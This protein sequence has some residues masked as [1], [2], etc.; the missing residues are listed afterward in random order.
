[1]Q[2]VPRSEL[3]TTGLA[4]AG[5]DAAGT[6]H[7]GTVIVCRRGQF[8]E[9]A[10]VMSCDAGA[11]PPLLFVFDDPPIEFDEYAAL[12]EEFEL[13]RRDSNAG[14]HGAG[15]FREQVGSLR[16]SEAEQVALF[17]GQRTARGR[18]AP[19][20]SWAKRMAMLRDAVREA[21]PRRIVYLFSPGD[22]LFKPWSADA[23]PAEGDDAVL[24]GIVDQWALLPEG[25]T[26][27]AGRAANVHCYR[28]LH[29]LH[30]LG[31]SLWRPKVAPGDFVAVPT[32]GGAAHYA[33]AL[34]EALRRN[35]PVRPL[36]GL[37]QSLEQVCR[38]ANAEGCNDGL[39]VLVEDQPD[40]TYLLAA[41]H[42]HEHRARIVAVPAPDQP[43]IDAAIAAVH[44]ATQAGPL[45]PRMFV[46][47]RDS[48]IPAE[49]RRCISRLE[50][51]V[52]AHLERWVVEE[53]GDASLTAF[54]GG[55]PY[56]FARLGDIGWR[57]KAIGHVAGDP[58]LL[59][60]GDLYSGQAARRPCA[61]NLVLDPG[62]FSR[63]E[64]P[65]VTRELAEQGSV[66]VPLSGDAACLSAI[67]NIAPQAA[68]ETLFFIT[69][70][71]DTAIKL[72][73]YVL[74]R[75]DIPQW[76]TL[77]SRPIVFNNSCQSWIGV[78]QEFI[79]VGARAYIGTL[80]AV[81]SD[82]AVLRAS[83][84]MP[85][86]AEG[87]ALA[88]AMREPQ[89]NDP[90]QRAYIVV[91]TA[92]VRRRG[93]RDQPV[94]EPAEFAGA[95]AQTFLKVLKSLG[96]GS[97][98]GLRSRLWEH[99]DEMMRLLAQ[100]GA[101][102]DQLVR[103]LPLELAL[104][105]LRGPTAPAVL[106]VSRLH[107]RCLEAIDQAALAERERYATLARVHRVAADLLGAAGDAAGGLEVV[108][109][110]IAAACS[111]QES[112]SN[113]L[114]L[115]G[116]LLKGLGRWPEA[117]EAITA[118]LDYS[119]SHGE[120]Q[121]T[122]GSLGRLTQLLKRTGDRAG[123]IRACDEGIVEARTLKDRREEALFLLD[124]GN[125]LLRDAPQLAIESAREAEHL[126][127]SE[128]D[129]ELVLTAH[130]L[131]GECQM[132]LGRHDEAR[133]TMEMAIKEA[134]RL[135]NRSREALLT[136]SLA[137]VAGSQGAEREALA[138]LTAASAISL[139]IGAV[140]DVLS[141]L[142]VRCRTASRL[143]DWPAFEQAVLDAV[144]CLSDDR[145]HGHVVGEVVV[146]LSTLLDSTVAAERGLVLR[147]VV[148]R[149]TSI[150]AGRGVRAPLATLIVSV[151]NL[152]LAWA[153]G[154]AKAGEMSRYL[155]EHTGNVFELQARYGK[156]PS[157]D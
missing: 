29:D 98:V 124:R 85:A 131:I 18:L 30:E 8:R 17:E 70:G 74:H 67:V 48:A 45:Q 108:K 140:E 76:L 24:T 95:G 5:P 26:W 23:E 32:G 72:G 90:S 39:A 116:D 126:F 153:E 133:A 106:D 142:H 47:G 96:K 148:F 123:A 152:A 144:A 2:A 62:E 109:A 68:L 151:L 155:D 80:W 92:T 129:D 73:D 86:I 130:G 64:A 27:P 35:V 107:A 87:R 37:V 50:E 137:A 89:G 46:V 94:V 22:H 40:A 83:K 57:R 157:V 121:G 16:H 100:A 84:A 81:K 156:P 9:A 56:T 110:G 71:S 14:T 1:M 122:M 55:V 117:I 97:P 88:D 10:I 150:L 99:Y 65:E 63:S 43:Q 54:T 154:N 105:Q 101:P 42:A 58:D 128:R 20:R 66:T 135:G 15:G 127:A 119:R 33:V 34:T 114:R 3:P 53:V 115:Q 125:L 41:L 78:G 112:P 21:N 120:R 11:I 61:L 145:T 31:R 75:T 149:A 44:S 69:H 147:S 51:V 141:L 38:S 146:G 4:D 82:S 139:S 93:R 138:L 118:S 19:Y 91:G 111:G 143:S 49:V 12:Y 7:G 79:R 25:E 104:M 60:Y 13:A 134:G 113:L 132:L 52:S 28:G 136:R 102:A 36:S 77:G 6:L 103:V 59:V